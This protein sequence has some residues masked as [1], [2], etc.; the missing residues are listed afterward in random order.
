M[1]LLTVQVDGDGT[2]LFTKLFAPAAFP[3]ACSRGCQARVR[4]RIKFRSNIQPSPIAGPDA[5]A[6][7]RCFQANSIASPS[8]PVGVA[9]GAAIV[10]RLAERSLNGTMIIAIIPMRGSYGAG[11]EHGPEYRLTALRL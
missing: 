4:S 8:L 3:A 11:Y 9:A 7:R 6:S 2:L 1:L 5:S 10:P